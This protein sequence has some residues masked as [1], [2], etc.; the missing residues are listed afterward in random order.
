MNKDWAIRNTWTF[1]DNADMSCEKKNC[2]EEGRDISSV[3][4]LF[5]EYEKIDVFSEESQ[6]KLRNFLDVIQT[7]PMK[8]IGLCEPDNY[9]EITAETKGCNDFSIEKNEELKNR[10]H[11]SMLG[12]IAGCMFGKPFE[13][14]RKW[15]VEK[16]LRETNNFPATHYIS[17]KNVS[18]E[19]IEECTIPEYTGEICH[20]HM[21]KAITDD[22]L[23]YP[24]LNLLAYKTYG[25]NITSCDIASM[26]L[27]HLPF[28]AIATAERIAYLNFVK[29]MEPPKSASYQNPYREFIG[30]QIRA[31]LWGWICPGKPKKAAEY[32]FK[33]ASISHIKNGIYGEMWVAAM[34]AG[35]LVK[36]D[37]KEIIEIGLSQIPEKSRIYKGIIHIISLFNEGKTFTEVVDD[38][39]SRWDENMFNGWCHVISNAE[40]V[41]AALLWGNKDFSKTIE[42]SVLPGFDTDC[43]GATVGS[44][45]GAVLGVKSLPKAWVSPINDTLETAI[46][47]YNNV[48][49]SEMSELLFSLI[50]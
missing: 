44:I 35:A 3:E 13:G 38:I 9:E 24:I 20:E 37:M 28:Y 21:V 1:I 30:A 5:D 22:D 32:A 50:K 26:W 36:D 29:L 14:R 25:E 49:I 7:L 17:Y 11:G 39:H 27:G 18:K 15:Q 48:K 16:Y 47:G 31:D 42:C 12:R 34:I 19:L 6:K 23:N 45:L 33:D 46:A 41:T 8:D 2:I 43:N 4:D 40:I 10:I